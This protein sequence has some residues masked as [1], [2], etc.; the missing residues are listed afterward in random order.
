[1]AQVMAQVMMAQ[2]PYMYTARPRCRS[3]LYFIIILNPDTGAWLSHAIKRESDQNI[4]GAANLEWDPAHGPG[5]DQCLRP[6]WRGMGTQ[7][8]LLGR[9][10]G[11]RVGHSFCAERW[12]MGIT[13]I[14]GYASVQTNQIYC[15]DQIIAICFGSL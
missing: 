5:I 3:A 12:T 15:G 13:Q 10:R 2:A 6:L 7:R 11:R 14:H 8:V 9:G 4:T 1:M